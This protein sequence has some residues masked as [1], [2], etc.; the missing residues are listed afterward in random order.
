MQTVTPETHKAITEAASRELASVRC[1]TSVTRVDKRYVVA[2]HLALLI[3][4]LE[5]LERRDIR[6]LIV[7]MPPRHGKSRWFPVVSRLAYRP[8]TFGSDYPCSYAAELATQN[9]RRVRDVV[10]DAKRSRSTPKSARNHFQRNDGRQP[11][12]E[13]SLRLALVLA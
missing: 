8:A 13:S 3:D 2:P 5:A 11:K 6:R 12:A 7:A 4:H 9:A 1:A 10:G